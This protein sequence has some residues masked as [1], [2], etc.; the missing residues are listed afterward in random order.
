MSIT[1]TAIIASA[2]SR[3]YAAQRS[4]AIGGSLG[5]SFGTSWVCGDHMST[6]HTS[7][8]HNPTVTIN[9]SKRLGPGSFAGVLT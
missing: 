1:P 6:A 3:P 4:I 9:E 7:I 5:A 2:L 8:G